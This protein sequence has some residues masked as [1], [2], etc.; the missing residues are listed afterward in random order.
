MS[1]VASE[2]LRKCRKERGW[3]SR[4]MHYFG[5]SPE[6]PMLRCV[7]L[8][9]AAL[10]SMPAFTQQAP[11]PPIELETITVSANLTPTPTKE[12]GSA[13]TI[14]TR[15]ELEQRQIRFVADALRS[16]PGV[17]VSRSGSVG[18]LTQVRL[19]GSEANQTLVLIDGIEVANPVG[20]AEFDFGNLL[21]QDIERIEVLRGPQSA[22]YGSDAVGGVV[23]IITRKGKGQTRGA[24][25]VEGGARGTAAG[26]ASLGGSTDRVDY[27]LSAGGL[28]TDGFS[29]FAEHLGGRERDG[30]RNLTA[31]GKLGVQALDNLRF[32]FVGRGTDY[33]LETD[34]SSAFPYDAD[35]TTD[36]RQAFGR[37]QATLDLFDGMWQQKFGA[38]HTDQSYLNVSESYP[39]STPGFYETSDFEGQ[40]TKF[41]YQSSLKV[42]G[43]AAG[44]VFVFGAEHEIEEAT[45]TFMPGDRRIE[46]SSLAGQYQLT[47][48]DSLFLT[49]SVRGDFNDMFGDVVTYRG[50]GAY[51]F[52]ETGTKI[53]GS[54]GTGIKNPTLFE[55]YGSS[56]NFQGNPNLTPE[57]AEGWDVGVDQAFF[58]D[59]LTVETTYFDQKIEDLISGVG[60]SAI[61]IEGKSN[62]HGVELGLSARVTD[63]LTV[64]AAYTWLDTEAPNG[65]ELTRRPDHLASLDV[66]YVFLDGRATA[67]LG[68]VYNGEQD[69]T[70]ALPPF[71]T[72]ERVTLDSFWI[73]NVRGS[74]RLNDSAEIYGRV[75]NVLDEEYEEI[76]GFG[77][78]GRTAIIGMRTSF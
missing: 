1:V 64:R 41:D 39:D 53:R 3:G 74:Y 13:V 33:E 12:V 26:G 9:S 17:A 77:G 56:A 18:S 21:A 16:V 70:F 69:D 36:G 72:S 8:A 10:F 2:P 55:L 27:F 51:V 48:W 25:F 58:D 68:V 63:H 15:E 40:K 23:N 11:L 57:N 61:N 49:G 71:Y 62:I 66:N 30:Y 52:S 32:D 73:V 78:A 28:R 14:I 45:S 60:N 31:F 75:E 54:W 43:E 37:A 4:V 44:H 24:A 76:Y 22:L 7:V 65:E 5:V 59:R 19:R 6:V 38:S 20:F 46:Q 67:N 47:L 29:Q 34:D 50:T 42:D 35:S